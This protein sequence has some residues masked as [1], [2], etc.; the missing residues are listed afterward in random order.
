MLHILIYQKKMRISLALFFSSAL[1]ASYAFHAPRPQDPPSKQVLQEEQ[2]QGN[3][4][5]MSFEEAVRKIEQAPQLGLKPKKIFVDVYTDWCGWCKKMDRETFENPQIA[6]YLNKHFYPV[7]LDAE[8]KEE[9]VFR[10]HTFRYVAQGQRGYHE[11]AAALLEGSMSYPTVLF[12]NEKIELVQRIPG[13]LDIPTFDAILHYLAE[14]K[15][16]SVP[17]ADFQEEFKKRKKP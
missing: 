9:I 13:Y 8:Q 17:W 1:L 6:A 7:K 14:D 3:V 2:E 12:L 11:L 5:W 16:L 10:G 4:R 15:H